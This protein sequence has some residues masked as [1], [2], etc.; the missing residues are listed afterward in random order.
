M[1][2]LAAAQTTTYSAVRGSKIWIEGTA[3]FIHTTWYVGGDLIGGSL[4]VGPGF[5][6]EPG[7]AATPGKTEAQANSFIPVGNLKSREKDGQLYSSHMDDVMYEHFKSDKYP[8]IKFKLTELAL[9]EAAKSKDEPYVFD[10]KGQLTISGVTKEISMAVKI[11]PL[12][13]KKLKISASPVIKMSDYQVGPVEKTVMNIGI[14]TGDEVKLTVD[15]MLKQRAAPT[16]A[17]K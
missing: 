16:A 12:E 4:T 15:W 11:L 9:K 17:A 10:S 14:K 3:N 5:P 2:G 13:G 8:Q 7:Q 1:T 6:T